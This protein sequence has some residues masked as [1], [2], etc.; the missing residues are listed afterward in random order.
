MAS[1]PK[2][3]KV[4]A[5]QEE[6]RQKLFEG[7]KIL[8]DAV[9]TTLGPKG[10]NVAI[11]RA[12]GLPIVV[13]D[14]VTVAREVGS[15]D[16]LVSIGID[17]VKEAAQKT[18]E[19][20][21]D[22]T[23]TAT[24]LAYELV[25]K[26]LNLIDEGV[27]P[28]VL[29]NQIYEVLPSVLKELK[30]IAKPVKGISDIAKVAYISSTDKEIGEMVAEALKKVG[31][32]GLV[33]VAEGG[34]ETE[35]EFTEGMEF[36]RGYI[37]PYFVTNPQ[38][39]E[40]VIENPKI[41]LI[42]QDLSLNAE[43][44]P[45]LERIAQVS[46]DI[47][48][49]ADSIKGD[50]LA[51]LATNK[52]KGNI[53]ACVVET[54]SDGKEDYLEDIAVLT[55]AKVISP[56]SGVDIAEDGWWGEAE[57]VVAN[58]GTT[59]IIGGKGDKKAMKT[60]IGALRDRIKTSTLF[61]KEKLEAR[62]ARLSTGIGVIRVGA[63][64]EI[65]MREKLERVKDAIGAAMAAREEGVIPG[66]GTIFL[67][68]SK[69][70]KG[71]TEGERLL[72]EVLEAPARKLMANSGE[73]NNVINKYVHEILEKG[74]PIGYEV[75]SGNLENLEE[76]GIIDPCKVVRLALE[77]ALAVGCSILT[78]DTIIG[79]VVDKAADNG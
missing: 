54:P 62:L 32:D 59:V 77:N 13:H 18:N 24:L 61:E 30:S 51:T 14:G 39:M 72:R 74:S 23:T 48:I 56:Q 21:G 79:I 42:N 25:R 41:V 9:T 65:D 20:A 10:R 15:E 37:S 33:T 1:P 55:G 44:V 46:K 7:V 28:M 34:T 29:R 4:L 26:G 68:L 63:K 31:K 71:R 53:N 75:S 73:P 3:H 70:L 36:K 78:T 11:Q 5:F 6:A 69:S 17:L 45:I 52:M 38:R 22:G 2:T 35:V 57:R 16:P 76:K 43:I 8:A 50:A 67:Q 27:N 19:E 49:I 64:T 47:V 60:M 58:K 66:G 40:S 12:W